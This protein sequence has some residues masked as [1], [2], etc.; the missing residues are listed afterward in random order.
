ME[1][2]GLSTV[3]LT[4]MP[5]ITRKTGVPRAVAVEFP[6]GMIWGLP[7]DRETHRKIMLHMFE[8]LETVKE[9]GTIME[10]PYVWPEELFKKRDWFPAENPPW[11]ADENKIREM[12]DFIKNGNPLD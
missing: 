7:G 12:L 4:Q 5:F 10:L 9:P 6:F 3:S 2:K 1:K 8:A 11:M